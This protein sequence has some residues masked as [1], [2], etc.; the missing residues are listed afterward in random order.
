[1]RVFKNINTM[2]TTGIIILA[3]MLLSGVISFWILF[4]EKR[5]TNIVIVP[6]YDNSV[7]E[8]L[9]EKYLNEGNRLSQKQLLDN[10]DYVLN[11]F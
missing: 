9:N 1:M 7:N 5:T 6:S 10:T 8:I 3:V 2:S 4:K 11:A